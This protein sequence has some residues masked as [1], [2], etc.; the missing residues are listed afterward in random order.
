MGALMDYNLGV[1][2]YYCCNCS[3]FDSLLHQVNN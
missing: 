2:Y 1:I 3:P